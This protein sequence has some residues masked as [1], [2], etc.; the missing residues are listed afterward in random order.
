L[1][2][3]KRDLQGSSGSSAIFAGLSGSG[4]ALFGLYRSEQEA[5][6][7]QHRVQQGGTRAIL[8]ETL[9]RAAY[10]HTMFAE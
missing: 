1:R 2:S 7:A 6:A 8:T 5:R 4:S 9:T 3:T 10:W